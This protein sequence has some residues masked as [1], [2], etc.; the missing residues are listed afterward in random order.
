MLLTSLVLISDEPEA[1][2]AKTDGD[3]TATDPTAKSTELQ[4]EYKWENIDSAKI[5]GPFT[6]TAMQQS[7]DEGKFPDGVFVRKLGSGGDFYTSKRI[8]F[9]LYT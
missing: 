4:W 5:H 3:S 9:E 8:D 6:S 2:K 1:K 7:V